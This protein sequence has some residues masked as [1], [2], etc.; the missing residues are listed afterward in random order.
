MYRA[1]RSLLLVRHGQSEWN[2]VK[3]WQ[4]IADSPLTDLGRRQAAAIGRL[5]A[6]G[7]HGE[8][9]VI[10]SSDLTRASETAVIIASQ[11]G[12]AE[13]ARD[14]RLREADAGPWQGMTPSE[15]AERWPGYLEA[16]RRP[17][18]FESAES[19]V[20]R[21]TE[22][23]GEILRR[24]LG[25]ALAADGRRSAIAVTHSGLIRS[26]RRHLDGADAAVPNLGGIWI[27]LVD[28][29]LRPGPLFTIDG[30]AV[31]G[32]DGPGEDPG[33]EADQPR[34]RSG[35]ERGLTS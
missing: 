30:V 15:I 13:V 20:A 26:L 35:A 8:F 4:G 1:E 24:E 18:G 17:A 33:E 6:A 21:A 22:V 25:D 10:A 34:D 16:H 5:L 7:D 3:R 14:P 12:M 29:E 27:E 32:V 9:S 23:C 28:D 31:G 19:V 2:A 11:L